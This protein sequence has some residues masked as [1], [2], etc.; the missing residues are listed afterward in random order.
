MT[1]HATKHVTAEELSEM[2]DI[3]RCELIQGEI[4][5]MAPAGAEHG[6]TAG[7]IFGR[8]WMF[9]REQ[10]L[11]E[12]YAADTGFIIARNPDTVRAPDV[13]FV[14]KDRVPAQPRR[15]FFDGAPDL[16]VKVV[17]PGDTHSELSAKVN[18]WLA[19]GAV[20]VWVVDP[21]NQVV[22]VHHAGDRVERYRVADIL[23]DEA[24]L[25]GFSVAVSE[26]FR[27]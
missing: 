10:N 20:S 6:N 15:G 19:A 13:A 9:V 22:D 7:E 11:G 18:Q 23:R 27:T 2:G 17:S 12:V 24:I 14:R 25:P 5:R 8:I 3:G 16:A 21:P 4:I 26:I 1:I